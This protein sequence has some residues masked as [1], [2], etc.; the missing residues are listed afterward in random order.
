[1]SGLQFW[2]KSN[3]VFHVL[4][5]WPF[6]L[7]ASWSF[8][9]RRRL[10]QY[11]PPKR[12]R[13]FT[14]LHDVI[15]QKI[16]LFISHRIGRANTR[17]RYVSNGVLSPSVVSVHDVETNLPLLAGARALMGPHAGPHAAAAAAAAT[18]T[19]LPPLQPRAATTGGTDVLFPLQVQCVCKYTKLICLYFFSFFLVAP[20]RG[21]LLP[22]R[23]IGLSFIS[24]LI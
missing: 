15:S 21:S 18:V 24:F 9:Q 6:L 7:F 10:M 17:L 11:I 4:L 5:A 19:S 20:T 8:F 1:M 16:V 2:P 14:G 23:S 12:R 13:T 3:H 22:L